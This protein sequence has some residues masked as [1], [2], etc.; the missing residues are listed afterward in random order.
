MALIP[1]R[2]A[3]SDWESAQAAI[4]LAGIR[5]VLQDTIVVTAGA[6][7]DYT[8][9]GASGVAKR[10]ILFH[11]SGGNLD[12]R[13]ALNE[14]ADATKMPVASGVY[15]SLEVEEG[16]IVSLWNTSASDITVNVMEIG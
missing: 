3:R 7:D 10:V 9:D 15:F 16:D 1:N 4:S 11:D 12:I 6:R 2:R 13:V 5:P 8:V 14:N